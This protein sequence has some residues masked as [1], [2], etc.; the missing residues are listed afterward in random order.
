MPYRVEKLS[1]EPILVTAVENPFK[2]SE[3]F[4]QYVEA[5][6]KALDESPEP[7]FFISDA[8]GL[9]V[10][11]GDVVSGLAFVTKGKVTYVNHPNMRRM[12]A[13]AD[14]D[15]I[16][17][18]VNALGQKQYGGYRTEVYPSTEAALEAIR[19]EL[20]ELQVH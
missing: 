13:I 7:L 16:R 20:A 9:K 14:S 17:M 11:F 1:N 12:I 2:V 19:K 3:E 10:S 4:P 6:V 18:A 5:V 8:T 15:L